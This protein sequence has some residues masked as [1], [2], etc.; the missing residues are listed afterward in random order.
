MS[1]KED[2]RIVSIGDLRIQRLERHQKPQD[3]CRHK[4]MEMD[5][6]GQIVLC[7]DCGKQLTAYWALEEILSGYQRACADLRARREQVAA[8]R[9]I[10]LHLVAAKAVEEAWRGGMAPCCPHCH[11]AILPEDGLGGMRVNRQIVL[12]RRAAVKRVEP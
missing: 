9:K 4:H 10:N 6:V 7:L 5:S 3:A 11:D 12:T 1:D 2:S 8:E